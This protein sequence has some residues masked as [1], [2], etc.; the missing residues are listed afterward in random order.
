LG[1]VEDVVEGAVKIDS[2]GPGCNQDNIGSF[3]LAVNIPAARTGFLRNVITTVAH[4]LRTQVEGAGRVGASQ[5]QKYGKRLL[6]GRSSNQYCTDHRAQRGVCAAHC[7]CYRAT[8]PP[9]NNNQ[10]ALNE[11]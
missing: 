5:W 1:R 4:S 7:L 10:Q 3:R 8:A 6:S 9:L 11:V 2:D